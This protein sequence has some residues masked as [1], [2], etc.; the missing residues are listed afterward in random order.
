MEATISHPPL[1]A[2]QLHLLKLKNMD[3]PR[4]KVIDITMFKSILNL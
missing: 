3:F 1:N 2:V 4:V